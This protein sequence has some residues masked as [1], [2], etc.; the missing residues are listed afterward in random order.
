MFGDDNDTI[1]LGSV[2]I[3]TSGGTP[4]RKH[5]ELYENATIP[6]VKSKEL[7]GG[8]IHETEEHINHDALKAS[9]AKLLPAH[10]VLVA[11]YGA[12]V[13]EHGIISIPMACNQ[14][15]C[16]LLQ[17]DNYPYPYLFEL[18]RHSK[19]NLKNM[20]VG[21]AQQNISQVMIKQLP[22]HRSVQKTVEFSDTV[23]ASF[24]MIESLSQENMHLVSIRD[25]L[26]PKLMSGEIDISAVQP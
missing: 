8:F 12:T 10:S 16:A 6:W 22:V 7:A 25:T 3:T 26:L 20:A 23:R 21:S 19:D 11:M 24:D 13:G 15:V 1:E 17:N 4:S 18:L 5:P 14:A 9:A 2:I